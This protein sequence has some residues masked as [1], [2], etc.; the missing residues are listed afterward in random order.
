MHSTVA[1]DRVPQMLQ[2]SSPRLGKT[3]PQ[4]SRD[5]LEKRSGA[6]LERR[7]SFKLSCESHNPT[8]EFCVRFLGEEIVDLSWGVLELGGDCRRIL[9]GTCDFL[10]YFARGK[11]KHGLVGGS[12]R[13]WIE[14]TANGIGQKLPLHR[15]LFRQNSV[16]NGRVMIGRR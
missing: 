13:G 8:H 11:A 4:S 16:G 3:L 7:R 9:R 6:R 1:S 2:V 10:Y 12:Y 14:T 15:R 5:V